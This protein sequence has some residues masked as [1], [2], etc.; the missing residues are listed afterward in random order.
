MSRGLKASKSEFR[1]KYFPIY[2]I[3]I[4]LGMDYY[5]LTDRDKGNA[6]VPFFKTLSDIVSLKDRHCIALVPVVSRLLLIFISTNFNR[7]RYHHR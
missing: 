1:G 6:T 7:P 2:C 3:M 4:R 5:H